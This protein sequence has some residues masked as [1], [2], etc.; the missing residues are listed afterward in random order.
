MRLTIII[1]IFVSIS[2]CASKH[3]RLMNL[4]VGLNKRQVL[5]R[6]ADPIDTYRSK[7]MDHWVYESVKRAKNSPEK[8]L[9]THTLSFENGVLV[10]KEFKRSFTT[11]EMKEFRKD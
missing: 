9:Y 4:S 10:N 1:A 11:Q 3:K 6:F 2:A 8:L 5:S 7:G